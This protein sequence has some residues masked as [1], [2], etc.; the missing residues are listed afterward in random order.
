VPGQ[1]AGRPADGERAGVGAA[2]CF[3]AVLVVFFGVFFFGVFFFGVFFF[4]VFFAGG[5]RG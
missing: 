3:F 5:G 4:G 2:G 1:A